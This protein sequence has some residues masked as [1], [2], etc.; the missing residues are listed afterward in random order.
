MTHRALVLLVGIVSAAGLTA[1]ASART[2]AGAP[3]SSAS[4]PTSRSGP[5][6]SVPLASSSPAPAGVPTVAPGASLEPVSPVSPVPGASPAGPMCVVAGRV[7]SWPAPQQTVSVPA[8]PIAITIVWLP[9]L[10]AVPCQAV[11]TR[12]GA[13]L[14]R[15]LAADVDLARP[16]GD[17][18]YNCAAD[19]ESGLRLYFSYSG[20]RVSVVDASLSGCHWLSAP[21]WKARGYRTACSTFCGRSRRPRSA[22]T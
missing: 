4:A 11:L 21:G 17:G 19:D 13:A 10:N 9:G 5:G 14:A 1:C 16:V 18:T 7:S 2:G 8:G 12:S 22:A 6:V 3:P 15:H 20:R